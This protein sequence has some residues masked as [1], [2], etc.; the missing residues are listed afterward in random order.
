M[1]GGVW[2]KP[3]VT[4]WG[5]CL[6]V[7][8]VPGPAVIRGASPGSEELHFYSLSLQYD[9]N[10]RLLRPFKWTKK[11]LVFFFFLIFPSVRVL[12]LL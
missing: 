2:A 6:A 4:G 12:S 1:R 9:G 5:H 11:V 7:V 8:I 10:C 3:A